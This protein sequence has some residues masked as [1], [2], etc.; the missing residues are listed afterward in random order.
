MFYLA[1]SYIIYIYQESGSTVKKKAP[2]GACLVWQIY[3][4]LNGV[5]TIVTVPRFAT[6]VTG[7]AA[8]LGAPTDT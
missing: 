2:E 7:T 4:N 6:A 1:V 5:S 3:A 8:W